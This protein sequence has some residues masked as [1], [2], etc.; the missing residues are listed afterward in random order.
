MNG[1]IG[2]NIHLALFQRFYFMKMLCPMIKVNRKPIIAPS[3]H[4]RPGSAKLQ[5]QQI[6]RVYFHHPL[7]IFLFYPSQK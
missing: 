1:P 2:D 7:N 6:S 3:T 5:P 4:L